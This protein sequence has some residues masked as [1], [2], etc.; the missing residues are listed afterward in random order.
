VLP[1]GRAVPS[2]QQ[3]DHCVAVERRAV[4]REGGLVEHQDEEGIAGRTRER[5]LDSEIP[6]RSAVTER[7]DAGVSCLVLLVAVDWLG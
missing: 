7:V 6:E 3:P 1:H 5:G 4:V 2:E